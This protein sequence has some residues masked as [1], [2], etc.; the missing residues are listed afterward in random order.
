MEKRKM[1]YVDLIDRNGIVR[2]SVANGQTISSGV[3]A[4]KGWTLKATYREVAFCRCGNP[5][6]AQDDRCKYNDHE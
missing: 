4:G 5:E 3:I 6:H 1:L 2:C